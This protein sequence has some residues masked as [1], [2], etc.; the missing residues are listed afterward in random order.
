MKSKGKKDNGFKRI[1]FTLAYYLL[2]SGFILQGTRFL[3]SLRWLS[4]YLQGKTKQLPS[5]VC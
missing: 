5:K 4:G 3:N 2:K 1:E